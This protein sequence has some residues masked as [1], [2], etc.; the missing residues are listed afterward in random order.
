MK[1]DSALAFIAFISFNAD[2]HVFVLLLLGLHLQQKHTKHGRDYNIQ[3]EQSKIKETNYTT[4]TKKL[5][6]FG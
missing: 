1:P 4:I 3:T 5:V 2:I 6:H